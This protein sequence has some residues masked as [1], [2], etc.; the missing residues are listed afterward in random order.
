[1]ASA[2]KSLT[3]VELLKGIFTRGRSWV[4][5][6]AVERY[7]PC[8]ADIQAFFHTYQTD[9]P[10]EILTKAQIKYMRDL[11]ELS[12]PQAHQVVKKDFKTFESI[13]EALATAFPD[14]GV[15]FEETRRFY[16]NPYPPELAEVD[17]QMYAMVNEL[18][19]SHQLEFEHPNQETDTDWDYCR[20]LC[21]GE[22]YMLEVIEGLK[23]LEER[24]VADIVHV[25]FDSGINFLE[26]EEQEYERLRPF[27]KQSHEFYDLLCEQIEAVKEFGNRLPSLRMDEI[28][29]ACPDIEEKLVKD[30][31]E[32]KWMID[33]E[34]I[35]VYFND[36]LHKEE[37][38]GRDIAIAEF[39]DTWNKQNTEA[40]VNFVLGK[41]YTLP[42]LDLKVI[43]NLTGTNPIVRPALVEEDHH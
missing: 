37:L 1:M 32:R 3:N 4:T 28:L 5:G 33:D 6:P 21:E 7:V 42:P 31:E 23:E 39:V 14:M 17:N 13:G 25:P 27:M 22:P 19:S 20:R 36:E 11:S 41:P 35:D 8:E 16:C 10:A 40:Y 30:I 34:A 2:V 9:E 18:A 15:L 26:L 43:F 12:L 24:A 38:R 29:E